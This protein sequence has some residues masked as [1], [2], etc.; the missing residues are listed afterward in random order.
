MTF[1]VAVAMGAVR[2]VDEN[3]LLLEECEDEAEEDE[4]DEDDVDDEEEEGES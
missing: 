3:G 2:G 4:E 1:T